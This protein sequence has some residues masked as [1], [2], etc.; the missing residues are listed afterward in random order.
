M[1]NIIA[2]GYID[3]GE[4]LALFSTNFWMIMERKLK[5]L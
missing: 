4:K 3:G 1:G 2:I 5:S